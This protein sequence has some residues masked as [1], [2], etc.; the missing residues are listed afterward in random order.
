MVNTLKPY[1]TMSVTDAERYMRSN[2]ILSDGEDI[3]MKDSGSNVHLITESGTEFYGIPQMVDMKASKLNGI[4]SS[5][6]L[7]STPL[8]LAMKTRQGKTH[9]YKHK[10]ALI[11]SDSTGPGTTLISEVLLEQDGYSWS[12]DRDN[13]VL[14]T[15]DGHDIDLVRHPETGFWFL[16]VQ[17][18][19]PQAV[20]AKEHITQMCRP[21][22]N[23][24]LSLS[25]QKV[26][27]HATQKMPRQTISLARLPQSV[28]RTLTRLHMTIGHVSIDRLKEIADNNLGYGLEILR[29]I[30]NP[31][32]AMPPCEGCAMAKMK[33]KPA[34]PYTVK[35]LQHPAWG[36]MGID[37][38]GQMRYESVEGHRFA[39]IIRHNAS[40]SGKGEILDD[41]GTGFTIVQGLAHKS[42]SVLA[43]H[44]VF[45]I[46]KP[47]ARIHSD[48]ASE[49]T[50]EVAQ[51]LFNSLG[52]LH[53]VTPPYTPYA[54]GGAER[55]IGLIKQLARVHMLTSGVNESAWF[56]ALQYGNLI[57]N[58]TSYSPHTKMTQWEAYY[59]EKPRFD[60]I[61]PFGC[62]AIVK[63]TKDQQKAQGID[64]AL[65]PRGILGLYMGHK[66]GSVI[67]PGVPM[68]IIL[69][70][71]KAGQTHIATTFNNLEIIPDIFPGR[72]AL[73]VPLIQAQ[74]TLMLTIDDDD[75][76]E[77][78]NPV[79]FLKTVKRA[80]N[81]LKVL[82]IT[83]RKNKAPSLIDKIQNIDKGTKQ[84][85]EKLP[86][87]YHEAEE[88]VGQTGRGANAKYLIRWRGYDAADDTWVKRAD[89][90]DSLLKPYLMKLEAEKS[91]GAQT[92]GT[93]VRIIPKDIIN[94][95]NKGIDPFA[96]AE[97]L[98]KDLPMNDPRDVK[99][100]SLPDDW[101]EELPYKD[102]TYIELTPSKIYKAP[103]KKNCLVG[104]KIRSHYINDE[105]STDTEVGKII[106]HHP[107]SH[108]WQVLYED[109]QLVDL[110][111]ECIHED[112][113]DYTGFT[114][115]EKNSTLTAEAELAAQ[116]LAATNNA[117]APK[118]MKK[119]LT[120]PQ[121]KDI[122]KA[123]VKELDAFKE[124]DVFEEIT[125]SDLPSK[126]T[127]ILNSH[128]VVT[129]KFKIEKQIIDGKET[130]RD[131][132]DRWKARL[133]FNGKRQ[134][135]H[136]ATFSPTPPMSTIMLLLAICCTLEWDVK[137]WDL[138]NAFCGTDLKGREIY[139][140]PPQGC[141]GVKPG[142][143]WRI[144]KWV[145][146][147]QES[148][149]E[150]YNA[151]KTLVLSFKPEGGG[152][153][154]CCNSEP[155]LYIVKNKEGKI[156][157]YLIAYVDDLITADRSEG[158]KISMELTEHIRQ[159]W[160]IKLEGEL[161]RYL[162]IGFRRLPDGGWE[163]DATAYIMKAAEKFNQYELPI[164][165]TTPMP[166]T[167]SLEVNDW[168]DETKIDPKFIAHYRTC[169]GVL[170]YAVRCG[171]FDT[172][173]SVSILS[174]YL[175]KP[176]E[177]LMRIAYRTMGY[178]L[179]TK[180]LKITYT[181]PAD[182]KLQNKLIA[183]ADAGYA[184][185]P[186][187]RKS[188]D[189][190]IVWLNNGPIAYRSRKQDIVTLSTA[191]A[192]LCSLVSAAKQVMYCIHILDELGYP[193]HRV[194]IF[195][196]NRAAISLTEQNL[197]PGGSRTK[198]MGVRFQ[199][200]YEQVKNETLVILYVAS[201]F[202]PADIMTKPLARDAL[203]HCI[204]MTLSAINSLPPIPDSLSVP[205]TD[206]FSAYV[207]DRLGLDET[208]RHLPCQIEGECHALTTSTLTW[209]YDHYRDQ[210]LP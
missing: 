156:I 2:M 34:P 114:N 38:T 48:N 76:N 173:Y 39:L 111:A 118:G 178:L 50:G 109:G 192:E 163:Y 190:Y 140:K 196:D 149:R 53:T 74:H 126:N 133:V 148:N 37:T 3:V 105:L 75:D 69:T 208:I 49:F 86:D 165:P 129:E 166:P 108:T 36:C 16:I 62:L 153:I 168:S 171:R 71:N 181:L 81:K 77:V 112:L 10:K 70:S 154:E 51:S 56:L 80:N 206:T 189:G 63:V 93:K 116:E 144:K 21:P 87:G 204:K 104:R 200:I 40:R 135:E 23:N 201:K 47:P 5:P 73:T 172:A 6:T 33:L 205:V 177:K 28:E 58:M 195:E 106:S 167:W 95:D 78:L 45:S 209:H 102:A 155:C 199:W 185:C 143:L 82:A 24:L 186:L 174:Q 11:I 191:E 67:S 130:F 151:F 14:H 138:G 68:H 18:M 79:S 32:D 183:A 119:I 131:V 150:F 29:Q 134:K 101:H 124:M 55:A 123:V 88:I 20:K 59:G 142:S 161:C 175:A 210:P 207:K 61:F 162:G 15:P 31:T 132:F 160:S 96:P 43:L 25:I 137:H 194:P 113:V 92:N 12:S 188:Q 99:F 1:E 66:E 30:P 193:Q 187:T 197:S 145:Y 147:L 17:K 42:D 107:P 85:K 89:I 159:G 54:N 27:P 97:K 120:H 19:H 198:H 141:P 184:D 13:C 60:H 176:T 100:I 41:G 122:I 125:Y 8:V 121:S 83:T 179:R 202:N 180:D 57:K 128:L 115:Y 9:I 110:D 52:I 146:G 136:G 7:G 98:D 26:R 44:K 182:P 72:P 152:S 169:I 91:T 170:L 35:R 127:E 90:T 158:K 64:P 103:N 139:V 117:P 203:E 46:V 94:G 164:N 84:K 157:C 4:G 22:A 65:G